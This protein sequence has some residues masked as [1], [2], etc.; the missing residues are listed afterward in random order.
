MNSLL[1]SKVEAAL[2][3]AADVHIGPGI[4][5]S[6]HL[7]ELAESI[8][9]NMCEPFPVCAVVMPPGFPDRAVGDEVR[10]LC[11]AVKDGYWLVYQ[12][13]EDTFYCFWGQ[14]ADALGAHGVVGS[15]LYCWSA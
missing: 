5:R 10:G 8:R 12:P 2:D 6:S 13:E 14:S 15:P 1:L 3:E 11:F 7:R 4:D 9:R